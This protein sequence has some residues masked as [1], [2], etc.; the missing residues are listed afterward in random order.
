MKTFRQFLEDYSITKK[1]LDDLYKNDTGSV[2][3][4][5]EYESSFKNKEKVD[6]NKLLSPTKTKSIKPKSNDDSNIKN[7]I[8]YRQNKLKGLLE[9]WERS[10]YKSEIN[11]L[12]QLLKDN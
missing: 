4:S 11:E 8:R 5:G 9:P 3:R 1:D 10:K 12:K 7:K 6:I 2:D